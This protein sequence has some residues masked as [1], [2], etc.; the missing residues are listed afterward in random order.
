ML[1]SHIPEVKLNI[2]TYLNLIKMKQPYFDIV[3]DFCVIFLIYKSV[4]EIFNFDI[5]KT[6][7]LFIKSTSN[8]CT[9]DIIT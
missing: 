2:L 6:I 8:E 7:F 3:F 4:K 9:L 5:I 1:L